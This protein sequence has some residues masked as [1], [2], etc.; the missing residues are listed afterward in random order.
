HA[1]PTPEGEL[2]VSPSQLSSLP[3]QVSA[4]G[5]TTWVQVSPLGPGPGAPVQAHA[6]R[7]S[8]VVFTA[9]AVHETPTP[10]TSSITPS[11]SSSRPLQVSTD[12]ATPPVHAR[13]PLTHDEVP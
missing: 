11:Q 1:T 6:A 5:P 13:A 9:P 3:L 10:G 7:H 2:S 8:P 4:M 12:F